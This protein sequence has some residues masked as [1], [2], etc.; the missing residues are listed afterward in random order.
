MLDPSVGPAIPQRTSARIALSP[1]SKEARRR[2]SLPAASHRDAKR[3]TSNHVVVKPAS[4]E[5]ISSLIETLSAISSPAEHHFDSLPSIASSQSTP[6]LPHPWQAEFPLFTGPSSGAFQGESMRPSLL[7][8]QTDFDAHKR[9]HGV[10]DNYFLHPDCSSMR[11]WSP[12]RISSDKSLRENA[13]EPMDLYDLGGACSI[14][15]LSV[16]PKPLITKTN[17]AKS[18]GWK[19]LHSFGSF[20]SLGLKAS[21][22]S[23]RESKGLIAYK[24][25]SEWKRPRERLIIGDIPPGSPELDYLAVSKRG[26]RNSAA[27]E[28]PTI[29]TRASSVQ[30]NRSPRRLH[31]NPDETYGEPSGNKKK[32][33]IPNENFIPTRDSSMRHSQRLS[34]SSRKRRSQLSE[35]SSGIEPS[36]PV[37][38]NQPDIPEQAL[39]E[40]LDELGE[41]SVNR[42]IKEL[43][44][45]KLER[46]RSSMEIPTELFSTSQTRDR[47]F[48]PSPDP[49]GPLPVSI[50][51][52][53][54]EQNTDAVEVQQPEILDDIEK[55]A[56][57]PEIVQRINRNNGVRASS[58]ETKP[59]T[60][61][62]SS[63]TSKDD[64]K[65][66][67]FAVP[68]RSNSRLLKRFSRPMSPAPAEKRKTISNNLLET[69]RNTSYQI[70]EADLISDAVDEYL[71]SPRLSQKIS[72]PQTGRVI[73]FSEVG[74]PE[75]SVIFCCVGM[76]LTRFITA[77]YDELAF[78]LK[79]RLVTPDRPGV[80][81][82]EPH[83][84]GLDTPLTWPDDVRAICQH[85]K[86]TKFSVLAHS[87]G[88]IYALATALRMPQHIRCRV[89][90]LAPWIPPSQMY[91]IGAQQE[92][93]PA[94]SLP[95][96]Q[97]FL[98]SLPTTF[99]KAANSSFLSATSASV[100]TSLPKSPRRSKR[101]ILIRSGVAAPD[102]QET[103][104]GGDRNTP[105]SPKLRNSEMA[106]FSKENRPL[107]R[108]V[109][110]STDGRSTAQ[111][112]KERR[113]AYEARLTEA[114]WD[115]STTG[116][117]PAVDLLVCLE[118]RQHI[119][120]RYVDITRSV[121]IHHGSK[122]S[123]VPVDNVKWLGKTM[124]RC[125]VRVVEGEGH[126]LMASAGVMGNVL[127][128]MAQEWSDW[129]RVVK[130]KGGMD[131]RV[132][133]TV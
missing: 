7:G 22:D 17:S 123:R 85:L 3:R 73:S 87:A 49:V 30:S 129:N 56:P 99:L 126:G 48:T 37:L 74:D 26:T 86:I 127:M 104:I 92:P 108:R 96:S 10:H 90:L 60:V 33:S 94:K 6:A 115:A 133:N 52:L 13:K 14:G 106:D 69:K 57:A 100:T 8:S 31:R 32:Y 54:P 19:G 38:E 64:N 67:S 93:S 121:V 62:D 72:D 114:I 118:R 70:D 53:V 4:T 117:N 25:T 50:R 91:T 97:R 11:G 76:G 27:A 75:G 119:G 63:T 58:M 103:A 46:E 122:D 110:T 18:D 128:E 78:T 23:L 51:A 131:R 79:L 55:G 24:P 66:S 111:I 81:S 112:E 15:N 47:R 39:Q 65:R 124:R 61:A 59:A 44:T 109:S 125:E 116:A 107:S 98:R 21:V 120:F 28:P 83:T 101:R 41:D 1:K 113:S 34:P 89:H 2:R 132:M 71:L 95:Y 40:A 105:L 20:R 9:P 84:D 82:S 80:G 12:R 5:V 102:V 42:R 35:S 88:A 45:Q 130:G 43:K 36:K 16:E 29:P 68:Q 77:F